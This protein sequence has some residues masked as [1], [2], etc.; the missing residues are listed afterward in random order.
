MHHYFDEIYNHSLKQGLTKEQAREIAKNL[1]AAVEASPEVI[2]R[3]L[4]I[5][6]KRPLTESERFRM[7]IAKLVLRKAGRFTGEPHE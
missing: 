4:A 6:K 2:K 7:K 3:L 1:T 5:R